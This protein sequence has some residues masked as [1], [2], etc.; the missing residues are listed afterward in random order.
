MDVSII[1]VNYNTKELL[2]NCL[3][4]IYKQTK[5]IEFEVI[6]SDNGSTD[7]SVEMVKSAFPKVILIENNA[8]IG[9][10]AANN[11]G[12]KVSAG[13]YLF[14]LN[15]DTLLEN[16]ALFYFYEFA[17]GN[18]V[19]LLGGYLVDKSNKIIHSFENYTTPLRG[20]ARLSYSSFPV[21][22]KIKFIFKNDR[23]ISSHNLPARVDFIIGADLFIAANVFRQLHGFDENFFMYYE[24]EDLCR[25]A[26]LLNYESYIIN[27]P[28]I[29]HLE[30]ASSKIKIKK[31][32]IEEES[33]M[34][35]ARKYNTKTKYLMIKYVVLLLAVI[36]FFS[37]YYTFHDKCILFKV[38]LNEK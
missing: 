10:G 30:S 35:Y 22:H 28:K 9:F 1:I 2:F 34:H 24:D 32:I 8:N 25:R 3:T 13:K 18:G 6:V 33:F 4:S 27:G 14:F 7:G 20:I 26:R 31:M 21:L 38:L 15:S 19:S 12:A 11:K 36:R 29:I 16:N 23:V 5:Q 37:P 17:D